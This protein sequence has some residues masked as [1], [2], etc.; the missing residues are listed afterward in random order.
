[1]LWL[2][3]R[4]LCAI[5]GVDSVNPGSQACPAVIPDVTLTLRTAALAIVAGVGLILVLLRFVAF[6]ALRTRRA[7]RA[8]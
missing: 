8:G 3:D 5:V 7:I 2:L 6:D 1:M 4:P